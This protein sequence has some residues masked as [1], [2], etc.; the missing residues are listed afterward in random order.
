[1]KVLSVLV[2]LIKIRKKRMLILSIVG[3]FL[4]TLSGSDLVWA[5]AHLR[6]GGMQLCHNSETLNIAVNVLENFL[7]NGDCRLPVCDSA[8]VFPRGSDCCAVAADADGNG[9]CDLPNLSEDVR[10][11]TARCTGTLF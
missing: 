10:G 4:L 1:V 9:F 3:A 6:L 11:A 7:S 2:Y 5:E 8:N